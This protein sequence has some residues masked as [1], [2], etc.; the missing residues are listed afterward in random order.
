MCLDHCRSNETCENGDIVFTCAAPDKYTNDFCK[1]PD[2]FVCRPASTFKLGTKEQGA[3]CTPTGDGNAGLECLGGLCTARGDGPF[4]CTNPCEK[5]I[6]CG[7][8]YMCI[9]I[10]EGR[11]ECFPAIDN[12]TCK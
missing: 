5:G 12:Y 1:A 8:N 4:A 6:D 11:K 3:C 10:Y 9:E 2:G 7:P